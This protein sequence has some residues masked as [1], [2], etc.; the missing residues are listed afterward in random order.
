MLSWNAAQPL[1]DVTGVEL[2]LRCLVL[3]LE[4]CRLVQNDFSL[5]C[6]TVHAHLTLG[7]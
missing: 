6:A 1:T 7:T 3:F 4:G 5:G 2:S